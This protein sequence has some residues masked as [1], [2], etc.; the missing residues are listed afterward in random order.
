MSFNFSSCDSELSNFGSSSSL[1]MPNFGFSCH[2]DSQYFDLN[3]SNF[4][5]TMWL[6]AKMSSSLTEATNPHWVLPNL[7]VRAKELVMMWLGHIIFLDNIEC[8][9][10][11]SLTNC[12]FKIN[13]VPL[14][15]H[16]L[17][18][19]KLSFLLQL[20]PEIGFWLQRS[21]DL[22]FSTAHSS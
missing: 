1:A 22:C 5:K 11:V 9:F 19:W 16:S 14:K 7:L 13:L 21:Y 15:W 12:L 3:C 6:M 20:Q 8:W 18:L 4:G 2:N 10:K 17:R